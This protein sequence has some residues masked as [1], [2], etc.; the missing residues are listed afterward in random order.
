MANSVYNMLGNSSPQ[1][2]GP[3]GNMLQMM[4]KFNEFK[5]TFKGDP[6]QQIQQMLNS[7]KISQAQL[8]Q[9]VQMARQFQQFIH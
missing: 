1:M 4:S 5:S 8:N 6:Q 3:F 9:Y 7:G 2:G